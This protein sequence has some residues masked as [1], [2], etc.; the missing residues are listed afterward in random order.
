[1]STEK[2]AHIINLLWPATFVDGDEYWFLW[3]P[4]SGFNCEKII[5]F[6]SRYSGSH[7][8]PVNEIA[9]NVKSK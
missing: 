6:I 2:V 4:F 3:P 1:M 7:G 5:D 8:C 9:E